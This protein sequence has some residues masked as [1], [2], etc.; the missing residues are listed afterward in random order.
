LTPNKRKYGNKKLVVDGVKFDSKLEYTCYNLLKMLKFDFDFQHKVI[1]VDKFRFNGEGVRAITLTVD[2]VIR[3][4]GQTIYLDTKGFPTE[5]SKIK[6]KL[7]KDKLKSELFTDV[8]W[9]KN[10]KEVKIFINEL[11]KKV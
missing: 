1:L 9:L 10:Q 11:N 7:L 8:V 6:Y 4:N 3:A 2:F 5:V